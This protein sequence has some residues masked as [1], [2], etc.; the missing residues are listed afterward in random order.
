MCMPTSCF[1]SANNMSMKL[2]AEEKWNKKA[3]L[4]MFWDN[5]LQN[6]AMLRSCL[7]D[8][9]LQYFS[10]LKRPENTNASTEGCVPDF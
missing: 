5:N 9:R 2:W 3:G 6:M 1:S 10:D 4:S 8:V 7:L